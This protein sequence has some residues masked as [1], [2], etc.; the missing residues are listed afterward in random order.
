MTALDHPLFRR[1]EF[2]DE[3]GQF[4]SREIKLKDAEFFARVTLYQETEYILVEEELAGKIT[5][6]T[7]FSVRK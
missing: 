3:Q 6:T 1:V 4:Q 2:A 7:K 5:Y